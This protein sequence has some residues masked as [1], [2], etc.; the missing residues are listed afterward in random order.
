MQFLLEVEFPKSPKVPVQYSC[1]SPKLLNF[2][3]P[4]NR[5]QGINSA[6]LCSLAG[7]YVNPIPTLF[8]A[9]IDCLKIPAQVG[10]RSKIIQVEYRG[11]Q[12]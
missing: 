6:R 7:R 1:Q 2:K 5:F 12:L 3:G 11:L 8:L 4:R 10:L 9:P